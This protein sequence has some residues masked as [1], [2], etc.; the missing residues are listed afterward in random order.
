MD[1]TIFWELGLFIGI[2]TIA[3]SSIN[4]S[5]SFLS[6]C[7]HLS[8]FKLGTWLIAIF[9]IYP[10][11]CAC[12]SRAIDANKVNEGK[13]SAL[14]TNTQ[15]GRERKTERSIAQMQCVICSDWKHD[16]EFSFSLSLLDFIMWLKRMSFHEPHN[17]DRLKVMH[18]V[19][20][21]IRANT[22]VVMQIS[23]NPEW[24]SQRAESALNKIIGK[25]C[26][27]KQEQQ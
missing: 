5:P 26:S 13:S 20:F 19:D 14:H 12:Y 17:L 10:R 6:Y 15:R 1:I 4:F 25:W 9:A 21:R 23:M 2:F 11:S 8:R 18:S 24:I 7:V 22:A 16:F 3:S 27:E